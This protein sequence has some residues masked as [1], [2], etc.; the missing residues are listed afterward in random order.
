M[1]SFHNCTPHVIKILNI[2]GMQVGQFHGLGSPVVFAE[3][4]C[5][6]MRLQNLTIPCFLVFFGG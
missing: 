5:E 1:T 2:F 6:F 4:F 3:S